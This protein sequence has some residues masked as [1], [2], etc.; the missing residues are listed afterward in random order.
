MVVVDAVLFVIGTVRLWVG[1][2]GHDILCDGG[3]LHD[4]RSTEYSV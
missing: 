1:H 4:Y 2:G 3:G